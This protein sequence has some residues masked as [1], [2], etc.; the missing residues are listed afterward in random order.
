MGI[1]V[2]SRGIAGCTEQRTAS[3][4]AQSAILQS[5]GAKETLIHEPNIS[6]TDPV[7]LLFFNAKHYLTAKANCMDKIVKKTCGLE[8]F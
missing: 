1:H 4:H 2:Y 3:T 5:P 7:T 8:F 6:K